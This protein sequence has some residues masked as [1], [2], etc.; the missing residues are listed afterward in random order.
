MIFSI[1]QNTRNQNFFSPTNLR[2]CKLD[3]LRNNFS[4]SINI[5]MKKRHVEKQL[6]FLQSQ[7]TKNSQLL[8]VFSNPSNLKKLKISEKRRLERC[9]SLKLLIEDLQ[10]NV[11]VLNEQLTKEEKL[12]I[13]KEEKSVFL[14]E[15]TL[16]NLS[17]TTQK[18]FILN[19]NLKQIEITPTSEN[20]KA[21][22]LLL[23]KE[24]REYSYLFQDV[25]PFSVLTELQTKV[26]AQLTYEL[27]ST[28]Q[29]EEFKTENG[30]PFFYLFKR[31]LHFIKRNN[32]LARF[33]EYLPKQII[34]LLPSLIQGSKEYSEEEQL[35]SL[36]IPTISMLLETFSKQ[37]RK[38]YL[39]ICMR[40][41]E[42]LL[43]N[44]HPYII[45]KKLSKTKN[46]TSRLPL[47]KEVKE[48][49]AK[50]QELVRE[51]NPLRITYQLGNIFVIS[52]IQTGLLEEI[53]PDKVVEDYENL[54]WFKAFEGD[55][56]KK[57]LKELSLPKPGLLLS[58]NKLQELQKIIPAYKFL[59]AYNLPS[60]IKPIPYH[61]EKDNIVS[62]GGFISN[63][64][65][66]RNPLVKK[67]FQ[68]R[69]L[70][71]LKSEFLD[72][73][74]YLQSTPFSLDESALNYLINCYKNKSLFT[75]EKSPSV[76]Q[77]QNL[78]ALEV[79]KILLQREENRFYNPV[80]TDFRGRSYSI[81]TFWSYQG[82]EILRMCF[83]TVNAYSLNNKTV[84]LFLR[85]FSIYYDKQ[86]KTKTKEEQLQFFFNNLSLIERLPTSYD[87]KILK[88][89]KKYDFAKLCI[90]L[91]NTN[92]FS[93]PIQDYLIGKECNV[94]IPLDAKSS[95]LQL[96][97]LVCNSRSLCEK[98]NIIANERN[99]NEDIYTFISTKVNNYIKENLDEFT[100]NYP[101][102]LLFDDKDRPVFYD[103]ACWKKVIMIK[104]YAAGSEKLY[105]TFKLT[106]IE[107]PHIKPIS[108]K[109]YDIL[110]RSFFLK[111]LSQ[112]QKY[113]PEL[114]RFLNL[115]LL[116]SKNSVKQKKPLTWKTLNKSAIVQHVYNE[117]EEKK[118]LSSYNNTCHYLHVNIYKKNTFSLKNTW[119]F[120]ANL[121]QSCD[122]TVLECIL[123]EAKRRDIPIHG[124]A[125]D[126][127][128]IRLCD[129]DI[130]QD[131]IST[132]FKQLFT[133]ENVIDFWKQFRPYLDNKKHLKKYDKLTTFNKEEYEKLI[134]EVSKNKTLFVLS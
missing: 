131:I 53:Y 32:T 55:K 64:I 73:R 45:L 76:K 110:I 120:P 75:S 98:V 52:F 119:S 23:V 125:H 34:A 122:A 51:K 46:K 1:L 21:K 59:Y 41:G 124:S 132:V 91:Y 117:T 67:D 12:N 69:T 112:V 72:A 101:R 39:E 18:D 80:F 127:I 19:K 20:L 22:A 126:S 14:D 109:T 61:L 36:I 48:T 116:I 97:S 25:E 93:N 107:F 96:I 49:L 121:I 100:K 65:L 10:F 82:P 79:G 43:T 111:L 58:L 47:Q 38:S 29:I 102:F 60:I 30:L 71:V 3:I 133:Y 63:E 83:K 113:L 86:F 56:L 106:L 11:E 99:E 5:S 77:I 2:V 31:V 89:H 50:C 33:R 9:Q 129:F 62:F 28:I 70:H 24:S 94:L 105:S 134:E 4:S 26:L 27:K 103:R 13:F 115:C 128:L 66:K 88:M 123:L 95:G 78:T 87:L 37:E 114:P 40:V 42:N 57:Y 84:E 104:G 8:L 81:P 90:T 54:E 92:F 68:E 15:L 108:L 118:Y 130:I 74:N 16:S 85:L 35:E 17:S 44:L 6:K 7:I